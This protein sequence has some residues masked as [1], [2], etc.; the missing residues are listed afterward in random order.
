[1]DKI[2]VLIQLLES[3]GKQNIFY[4]TVFSVPQQSDSSP[5]KVTYK[6]FS[7]SLLIDTVSYDSVYEYESDR[8]GVL[9]RSYFSLKYGIVRLTTVDSNGGYA[10]DWILINS[11]IIKD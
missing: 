4:A 7:Q 11:K 10:H 6:G 2:T 9:S 5:Y 1:M 8:L 3:D